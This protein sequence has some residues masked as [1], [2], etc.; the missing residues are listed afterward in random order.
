MGVA[1]DLI[2][3][4][5]G[6]THF[7][8]QPPDAT[9]TGDTYLA[10]RDGVDRFVNAQAVYAAGSWNVKTTDGWTYIF[11]YRPQALPQNVTVL[12]GFIDPEGHKY[13]MERDSFGALIS[14]TSPSGN[15]L[16]FGE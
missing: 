13:E 16:H 5:G 3:E 6:R 12:T 1:V 10:V 11:P 4:D 15:W 7:V 14:V 9:Q 2:M 8:H